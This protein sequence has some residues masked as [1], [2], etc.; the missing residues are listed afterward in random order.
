MLS[1]DSYAQ[2]NTKLT[3]EKCPEL[4]KYRKTEQLLSHN[5]LEELLINYKDYQVNNHIIN[6]K[7]SYFRKI[8]NLR[9]LTENKKSIDCDYEIIYQY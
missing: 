2:F 9:I 1:E 6:N 7:L 4:V 5:K 3:I 8:I